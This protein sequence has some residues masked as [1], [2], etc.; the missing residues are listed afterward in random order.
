MSNQSFR[1]ENG[2]EK[3]GPRKEQLTPLVMSLPKLLAQLPARR[4]K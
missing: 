3:K 1:T 4:T 2:G